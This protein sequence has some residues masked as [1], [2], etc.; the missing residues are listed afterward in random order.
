MLMLMANFN[1][2]EVVESGPANVHDDQSTCE[3]C[4]NR[5]PSLVFEFESSL[6][7]MMIKKF[8]CALS[9]WSWHS[10]EIGHSVRT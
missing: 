4:W 10:I 6:E 8:I 3:Q 9:M 5:S 2:L 1:K 7:N